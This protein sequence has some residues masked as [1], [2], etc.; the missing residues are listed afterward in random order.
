MALALSQRPWLL[1]GVAVVMSTAY[2]A[3]IESMPTDIRPHLK[4]LPLV[5][6]IPATACWAF[7]VL[8]W[9]ANA[10]SQRE[11]YLRVVVYG[12][13]AP[14]VAVLLVGMIYGWS[15]NP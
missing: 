2:L 15:F 6:L 13:L 8:A 7:F 1:F 14:V 5:W 10:M 12:L 3:A 11:R 9:R 4:A